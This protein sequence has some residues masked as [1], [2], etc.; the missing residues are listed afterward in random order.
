MATN[1]PPAAPRPPKKR[2]IVYIDGFN[3]Y[4]GAVKDTPHKWL[5]I[6][7]YFELLR[8]DDDV[9]R[10]KYF[11]AMI[12]GGGVADQETYL[13]A[14]ATLPKVDIILGK[15][16][17]K[18]A[19]CR[20]TGCSHSGDRNFTA[21]EE[22]RT[23]V[24]IAVQMMDDAYQNACDIFVIVSGDSDLVPPLY[25]IKNRFPAKKVVVYV[26]ARDR[27]RGAAVEIRS[28][29]DKDSTLP[30]NLLRHSQFPPTLPDGAGGTIAK[31]PSW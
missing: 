16:K 30:Q 21:W 2:S 22:K 3:L 15:Y 31:P 24:N 6:Q 1:Q 12:Q 4:Y 9:I 5:N 29:A 27:I 7:R 23:D 10:I 14:L 13:K 25:M 20:V 17:T 19:A 11:S 18:R 26:P 28:A 8:R